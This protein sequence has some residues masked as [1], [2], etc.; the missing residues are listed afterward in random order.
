MRSVQQTSNARIAGLVTGHPTEKGKKFSAQYDVPLQSIY[1]YETF[2]SIRNDKAIEAVYIAL[3][4]SMHCEYTIRAAQAGKH[5][6][7]EKPMAISSA[8]CRRMIDACRAANVKLMIGYRIHYDVT[9]RKVYELVRSGAL[10]EIV[11]FQAGFYGIKN[12]QQWRLD[13]RL[14]GG[15]SLL[16]LGIYALNTIRWMTGKSLFSTEPSWRLV[17]R[18]K[19]LHP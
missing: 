11:A 7:C 12:K 8:E 16:D 14:S 1:T 15:G 9:F 6:F 13:R 5:V 4:N 19:D 3:P 10:G 2:D 18:A 17:R